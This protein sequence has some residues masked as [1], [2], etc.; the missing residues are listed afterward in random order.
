MQLYFFFPCFLCITP[1]RKSSLLDGGNL[2]QQAFLVLSF[3][4]VPIGCHY[5]DT[6]FLGRSS[7]FHGNPGQ[8]MKTIQQEQLI[9]TTESVGKRYSYFKWFTLIRGKNLGI[10]SVRMSRKRK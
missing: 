8:S 6:Y 5:L 3:I 10:R 4:Y 9:Q 1:Q 7:A 2:S